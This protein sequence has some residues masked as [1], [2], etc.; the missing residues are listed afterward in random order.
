MAKAKKE[1]Q[2]PTLSRK[3]AKDLIDNVRM[4]VARYDAGE[5]DDAEAMA[6]IHLWLLNHNAGLPDIVPCTGEA[7]SNSHI[8]YCGVCAPRWGYVGH[9]ARI[10]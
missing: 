7:H 5:W 2:G 9:A 6:H 3:A 8:D 10:A 1:F 4:T